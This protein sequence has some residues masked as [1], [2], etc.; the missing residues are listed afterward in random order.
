MTNDYLNQPFTDVSI[1][2]KR[3][4]YK[5]REKSQMIL[6]SSEEST[7]LLRNNVSDKRFRAMTTQDDYP[8]PIPGISHPNFSH[9]TPVNLSNSRP[10]QR[11][12]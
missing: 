3:E 5:H 6:S 9:L 2:F 7:G 10:H 1:D 4:Q 11:I 12:Y 8:L